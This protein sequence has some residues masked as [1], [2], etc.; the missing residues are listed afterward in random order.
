[1]YKEDSILKAFSAGIRKIKE[2]FRQ[3]MRD[4]PSGECFPEDLVGDCRK[5]L[6]KKRGVNMMEGMDGSDLHKGTYPLPRKHSLSTRLYSDVF[7]KG[8]LAE[9]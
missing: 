1:M 8:D 5:K 7:S 2:K 4:D 9:V 3:N 6:K